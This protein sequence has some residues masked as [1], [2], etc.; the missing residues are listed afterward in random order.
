MSRAI[1]VSR[2]YFREQAIWRRPAVL[3]FSC[4]RVSHAQIVRNFAEAAAVSESEI[5][6][7]YLG[8]GTWKI[9]ERH[10]SERAASAS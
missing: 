5:P 7:C 6:G 1:F 10:T 2:F 4:T 3:N 8:V 9:R